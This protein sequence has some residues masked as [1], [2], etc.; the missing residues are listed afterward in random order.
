MRIFGPAAAAV[1]LVSLAS[2]PALAATGTPAS[3]LSLRAA[4]K[5]DKKSDI[6]GAPIIAIIGIVAIVAGGVI[7]ATQDDDSPDSP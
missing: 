5:G 4:T 2:V 6:A 3:K 1:A 7:I